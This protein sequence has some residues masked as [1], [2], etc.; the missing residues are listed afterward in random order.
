MDM[1]YYIE[2]NRKALAVIL[3]NGRILDNFKYTPNTEKLQ[4]AVEN[5]IE[6]CIA[7]DFVDELLKS[8]MSVLFE[9]FDMLN[10]NG[11]SHIAAYFYEECP[12][13]DEMFYD[14]THAKIQCNTGLPRSA[15]LHQNID[16]IVNTMTQCI[17]AEDVSRLLLTLYDTYNA[18]S[19]WQERQ[20]R[21]I[22]EKNKKEAFKM[23]LLLITNKH[24]YDMFVGCCYEFCPDV[25]P[26]L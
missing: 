2:K 6:K 8:N 21:S 25:L 1:Y 23:L 26:Y 12:N 4:K 15:K 16:I 3:Y 5:S 9:I 11:Y 22:Y 24:Q 17:K 14:Y 19:E 7:T 13:S 10:K 18:I 20:I